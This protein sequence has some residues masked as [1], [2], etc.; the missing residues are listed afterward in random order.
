MKKIFFMLA[1]FA[2]FPFSAIASEPIQ[3]ISLKDNTVIRGEVLGMQNKV[4][5]VKT[6][7]L[8]TL[9][10]PADQIV[11][12]VAEENSSPAESP[13]ILEGRQA[14]GKFPPVK[15]SGRNRPVPQQERGKPVQPALAPEMQK[16]QDEAQAR[17]QS[18]MMNSNFSNRVSGLNET[19]EMKDVLSDPETMNAINNFD[20][21]S[22]MN[23]EKM[24]KLMESPAIRELLGGGE[25]PE[26]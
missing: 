26:Q 11:S 4:Y 18:M 23:N 22:L 24:K 6:Q 10:V 17:V 19:S 5:T 13:K 12:I 25:V 2:L 14:P 21:E 20:Y 8:G 9:N 3:I 15:A 16:V 7:T 1:V